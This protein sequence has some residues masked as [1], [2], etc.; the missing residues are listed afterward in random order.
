MLP[1]EFFFP[2][3]VA[4]V[5]YGVLR[6]AL[7]GL[8]ERADDDAEPTSTDGNDVVPLAPGR[9]SRRMHGRPSRTH[10]PS[11]PDANE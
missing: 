8:V 7:L 11:G 10:R 5:S 3:G 2:V 1:R 9:T 4:Y 6:A